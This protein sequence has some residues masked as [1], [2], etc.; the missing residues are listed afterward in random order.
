MG[1]NLL[2]VLFIIVFFVIVPMLV[3]LLRWMLSRTEDRPQPRGFEVQ[4]PG[5]QQFPLLE[6][7]R[8]TR[9]RS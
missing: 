1:F 2:V 8:D 4:M 3:V 9:P 6:Q 7:E 5:Q